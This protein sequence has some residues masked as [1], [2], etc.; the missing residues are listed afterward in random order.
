LVNTDDIEKGVDKAS[1]IN[2]AINPARKLQL[3]DE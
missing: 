3:K 2:S 1:R